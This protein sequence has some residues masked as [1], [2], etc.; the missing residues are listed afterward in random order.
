VGRPRDAIQSGSSIL[1]VGR[2][3]RDAEDPAALAERI[4]QEIASA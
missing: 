3:I 1:V 4:V 2:P